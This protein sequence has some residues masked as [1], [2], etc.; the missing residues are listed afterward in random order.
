MNA[1]EANLLREFIEEVRIRGRRTKCPKERQAAE[2]LE[3]QFRLMVKEIETSDS[4]K[5]M[6]PVTH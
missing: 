4:K 6:S 2:K 1:A 5:E 3:E